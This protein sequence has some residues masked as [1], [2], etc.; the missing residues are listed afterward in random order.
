MR[1]NQS[2]CPSKNDFKISKVEIVNHMSN[3]FDLV[4][5]KYYYSLAT[6]CSVR[7]I[8]KVRGCDS[9]TVHT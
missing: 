7:K 9:E 3:N 4:S 5:H 6:G 1:S 8:T 2:H